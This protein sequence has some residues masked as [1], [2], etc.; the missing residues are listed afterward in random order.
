[1]LYQPQ[2]NA[3]TGLIYGVEALVRWYNPKL[4]HV[5]PVEF[6]QVAE[7]V[8]IINDIGNFVIKKSLQDILQFN[9]R[10]NTQLHLSI[11]ISPKQLMEP[12]FVS[13]VINLTNE[14]AV[15]NRLITLEITEN[16]L[17]NDLAKVQPVLQ[18][19][20]N[21]G[22]KLSLDDFGTGYS[23]LSYLSNLPID[24]IKIDRSFID[25]LLT[26]D[27]SESLVKTIIAIGQF[28]DLTVIA[29]GVETKEQY[30][31]L[32][33]YRCDL[34]QGYYFD[35]PLSLAALIATYQVSHETAPQ[36]THIQN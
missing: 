34:V 13:N 18:S 32:R 16:V 25:K 23:S 1:M 2:I 6:I 17:I 30:D 27:Q 10:S 15:D 24:E 8:G 35:R 22:M 19:I 3:A 11:N 9:N 31:H 7:D 36:V 12:D 28:C 33:H 20:R 21:S 29:E 5:S 26:N 4:G 14:M